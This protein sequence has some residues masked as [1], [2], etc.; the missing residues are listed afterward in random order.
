MRSLT[1]AALLV[2]LC[3]GGSYLALPSASSCKPAAPIDLEARIVGDPAAPFGITARA[4]S[5]TGA[6]VDLEI[7]LPEGVTHS[8]GER[9]VR[10]RRCETRI[11]ARAKWDAGW[12]ARQHR[13]RP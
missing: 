13:A 2:P 3:A 11:D 9:K 10:G 12:A 6:P 7:I 4:S 5:R 1:L 8:A